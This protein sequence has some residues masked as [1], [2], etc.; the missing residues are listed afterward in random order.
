MVVGLDTFKEF[1]KEFNDKFVVIGGT[2]CDVILE[3]SEIEPR[4]T[5]DIDMILIA[6]KMTPEFGRHFWAFIAEGNYQTRQRKRG[7]GKEPAPELFRF[8]S[9]NA[10]YPV[11]IEL[12][13]T[14]P[15]ILG[16]PTGFHLTPI[17]AGIKT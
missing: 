2:A 9:P 7:E 5:D 4:A 17:P 3:D 11:R 15:D 16:E 1:F 8:T 6:D 13:S 10:G 14:Y 12:L